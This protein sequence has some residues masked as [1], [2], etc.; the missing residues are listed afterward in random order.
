MTPTAD[1]SS[2]PSDVLDYWFRE[3]PADA[4]SAM[5]WMRRGRAVREVPGDRHPLRSTPHR[6]HI[7]GRTSTP[8]E[9]AFLVDWTEKAPPRAMAP[10]GRAR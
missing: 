6:N 3:V 10:L 5:P 9:E 7:L 2:A 4:A 8:E 1:S